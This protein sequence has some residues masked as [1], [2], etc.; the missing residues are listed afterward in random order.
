MS[1]QEV[2]APQQEFDDLG[3]E[4]SS[5]LRH[6]VHTEVSSIPP[7]SPPSL[8]GLVV[9]EL[10]GQKNQDQDLVDG[11]LDENSRQ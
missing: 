8:I 2:R 1:N 9:L 4:F 5:R 6:D 7:S 3:K 11:T 10:T